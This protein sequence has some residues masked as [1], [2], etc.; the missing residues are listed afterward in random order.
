[1]DVGGCVFVCL[2]L[3]ASLLLEGM[4]EATF[5]ACCALWAHVFAKDGRTAA[6]VAAERRPSTETAEMWHLVWTDQGPRK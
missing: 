3:L 2:S 5:Q 1:M 4:P 6:T